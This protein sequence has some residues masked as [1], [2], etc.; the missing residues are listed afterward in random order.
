MVTFRDDGALDKVRPELCA[1]TALCLLRIKHDE[2]C[3]VT[4]RA[5]Y[6]EPDFGPGRKKR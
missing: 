5:T 4:P 2:M 3:V 1:R 6:P